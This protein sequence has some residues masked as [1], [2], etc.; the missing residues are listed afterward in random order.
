MNA[1][2][3]S[4]RTPLWGIV[5]MVL[6]WTACDDDPNAP[7]P[8]LPEASVLS[9]DIIGRQ[10]PL[11][12]QFSSAVDPRSALDPENF[13]VINQCTGLRVPG[14]LQLINGTELIFSPST[15]I[16]FL[17][18]LSVRV[19][20]ILSASGAPQT[21]PFLFTVT[22]EAP[23]VTDVT[24]ERLTSPTNNEGSGISFVTREFGFVSTT[25]GEVYATRTSGR[26]FEARYKNTNVIN[27]RNV[28]AL[29]A[30][31]VY[32][33]ASIL[34]GNAFNT[35]ALM[36]STDSGKT[37]TPIFT[38]NPASFFSLSLRKRPTAAPVALIVGGSPNL[39]A[40]RVDLQNDSVFQYGGIA[41]QFGTGGDLSPGAS[42]A[43]AVGFGLVTPTTAVGVA[44][45]SV[46][47]GRTF[48]QVA[49]PPNTPFLFGAGFVDDNTVLLLGDTS[50]VL[51]MN[52][53]T[54]A[55]TRLG[56]AAGI[57]QTDTSAVDGS[58]SV[59]T[60]TKA[61]FAPEDRQQ[62]F[63]VGY[64]TRSFGSR[65]VQRGVI[66]ITRDGGQTFQRQAVQGADDN[67][68]GFSP[69]RDVQVLARDF[70]A[71]TG[72]G[73][74]IAAR[75]SDTEASAGACSFEPGNTP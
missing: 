9:P 70:A 29:S 45:R 16:G 35:G 10:D 24:W 19:Q 43:V 42:A 4:R 25:P 49:L 12:I 37:F 69:I 75:R 32:M 60:F 36:E 61:D 1:G 31:S 2:V 17:T 46:N 6:L 72:D 59:F 64:V 13:V 63:V 40:W 55:V 18:P 48:S 11:R 53:A 73:G 20:N 50:T 56:A 41:N 57:P 23:P 8:E 58:I 52:V 26:L 27:T 34:A 38:R 5:C 47:G 7:D 3:F 22:T 14:A 68:L 51:R 33:T 74:F 67:G 30:D 44:H 54:G 65:N 66:L 21:T 15:Q 71:V 28:R 62:G 39:T